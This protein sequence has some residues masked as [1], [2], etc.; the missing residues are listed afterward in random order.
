[1]NYAVF[2]QLCKQMYNLR[3]IKNKIAPLLNIRRP[4]MGFIAF[5]A[6]CV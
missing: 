3:S 1:M 4:D 5:S 2:H 6:L